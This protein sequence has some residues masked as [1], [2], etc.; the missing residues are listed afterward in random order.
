MQNL[1]VLLFPSWPLAMRA[2]GQASPEA[3]LPIPHC[4]DP[5]SS[6]LALLTRAAPVQTCSAVP[7]SGMIRE[8]QLNQS[9]GTELW[10]LTLKTNPGHS[11]SPLTPRS[12]WILKLSTQKVSP[13]SPDPT[14]P[15]NRKIFT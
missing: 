1:D 6:A 7:P 11:L 10:A 12:S 5:A 14:G 15:N 4:P 13:L 8:L 2:G 3:Q 9:L